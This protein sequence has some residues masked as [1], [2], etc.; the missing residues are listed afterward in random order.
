MR[1]S[2]TSVVEYDIQSVPEDLLVDLTEGAERQI[3]M[4]EE[5][6]RQP[7]M[8]GEEDQTFLKN[9]IRQ[10]RTFVAQSKKLV[11]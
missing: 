10:L 4:Y 7:E 9:Q 2:L 8:S 3:K 6:L 11:Q 5:C 1:W